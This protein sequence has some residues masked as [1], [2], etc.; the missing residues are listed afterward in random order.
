YL[1]FNTLAEG[2][3]LIK[4]LLTLK[5]NLDLILA[6]TFVDPDL[7]VSFRIAVKEAFE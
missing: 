7:A 5:E 2:V 3:G 4:E 6:D 1:A